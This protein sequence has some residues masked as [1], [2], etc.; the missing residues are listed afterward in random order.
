MVDT[1]IDKME[2]VYDVSRSIVFGP[3]RKKE[4]IEMRMMMYTLMYEEFEYT[5]SKIGRIFNRDHSSV[6]HLLQQHKNRLATDKKYGLRWSDFKGKMC[7]HLFFEENEFLVNVL[8]S[9]E[10]C[11]SFRQ[12][13][14]VIKSAFETYTNNEHGK[15]E[16]V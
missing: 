6:I 5:K 11:T 8:S 15:S 16:M 4:Y 2:E 12:R 7:A 13:L 1:L 9:I 10:E 14:T 3:T